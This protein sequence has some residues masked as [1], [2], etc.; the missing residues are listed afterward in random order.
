[1]KL[2]LQNSFETLTKERRANITQAIIFSL[3]ERRTLE[4][5]DERKI[6]IMALTEEKVEELWGKHAKDAADNYRFAAQRS[7]EQ[8]ATQ[9]EAEVKG[10]DQEE[11]E[12]TYKIKIDD[13]ARAIIDHTDRDKLRRYFHQYYQKLFCGIEAQELKDNL[14]ELLQQ[15]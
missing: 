13:E 8:A 2:T 12:E 5:D 14:I 7:G 1:L 6:Q 15:D 9:G 11:W 4:E 10:L 3:C